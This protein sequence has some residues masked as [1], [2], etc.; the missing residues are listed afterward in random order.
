MSR[1]R[2]PSLHRANSMEAV[3]SGSNGSSREAAG[4]A[5]EGGGALA[6]ITPLGAIKRKNS[7]LFSPA[8]MAAVDD[9]EAEAASRWGMDSTDAL[10][11]MLVGSASEAVGA[12]N[13]R[14]QFRK[15][16]EDEEIASLV[17]AR[18]QPPPLESR[19]VY[20]LDAGGRRYRGAA[21]AIASEL[22]Q[23]MCA[24][25][26]LRVLL[27]IALCVLL[28]DRFSAHQRYNL[29]LENRNLRL[30]LLEVLQ[31]PSDARPAAE[32]GSPTGKQPHA[33]G[34]GSGA[35]WQ[36]AATLAPTAPVYIPS[37]EELAAMVAEAQQRNNPDRKA[38]AGLA[39][40]VT[41][42][43][44]RVKSAEATLAE[45]SSTL[46]NMYDR[47]VD[48][49][50]KLVL[51]EAQNA[52][53]DLMHER[54]YDWSNVHMSVM[55]NLER[56]AAHRWVLACELDSGEC[57]SARFD[58][59]LVA[60]LSQLEPD[61][62]RKT[63]KD[64]LRVVQI[65][66]CSGAGLAAA[67]LEQFGDRVEKYVI[68]ET[69]QGGQVCDGL[70]LA[71][72]QD[73]AAAV[74]EVKKRFSKVDVRLETG[75]AAA[76]QKSF[77]QR[78]L[79][80][81]VLDT[82]PLA[83]DTADALGDWFPLIR[84]D[85]FVLGHGYGVQ[86]MAANNQIRTMSVSWLSPDRLLSRQELSAVKVAVDRFQFAVRDRTDGIIRLAG[87]TAWYVHKRKVSLTSIFN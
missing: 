51:G 45:Q 74:A 37:K 10:A 50:S 87:D 24:R 63:G 40:A 72:S 69:Q 64:K 33:D 57:R 17:T 16:V 31:G 41:D 2:R 62:R 47:I 52:T 81:M 32:E 30:Q 28:V 48:R 27:G 26:G 43:D 68:L 80:A 34:A 13:R 8:D 39:S 56:H 1:A 5:D 4:G 79:D 58:H 73:L 82:S 7:E 20:A 83:P 44:Q 21:R 84:N 65:G 46:S 3:G 42:I 76:L 54:L 14:L 53:E 18:A 25:N 22:F 35:T 86:T 36:P 15:S 66:A 55:E 70:G 60:L 19:P 67:A 29:E 38:L 49:L 59:T 71:S 78:S 85:G 9:L 11:P 77:E 6:A 23:A 75:S 61:K 12:S